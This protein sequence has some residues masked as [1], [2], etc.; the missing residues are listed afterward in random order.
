MYSLRYSLDVAIA[1]D[2]CSTFIGDFGYQ[3]V[4]SL[5]QSGSGRHEVVGRESTGCI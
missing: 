1:S 2:A 4:L 5:F 3:H